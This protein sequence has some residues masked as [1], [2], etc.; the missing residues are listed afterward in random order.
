MLYDD[1][2]FAISVAKGGGGA[3]G[4][5]R[6]PPPPPIMLFQSFVGTFGSLSVHVY[7][8]ISM[9]FVPTKYLK[10]HQ[11]IERKSSFRM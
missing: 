3:Q 2:V 4:D 6:P 5:N 10:Y 7:K 8:P 9:S 11:N 1:R